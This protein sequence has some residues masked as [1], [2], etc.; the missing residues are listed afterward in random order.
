MKMKR[1]IKRMAK[2][3]LRKALRLSF[4]RDIDRTFN[5]QKDALRQSYKWITTDEI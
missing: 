3:S 5:L 1:I 4:E 2:I